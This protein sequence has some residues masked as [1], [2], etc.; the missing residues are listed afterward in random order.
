MVALWPPFGDALAAQE[1]PPSAQPEGSR[2]LATGIAGPS[3]TQTPKDSQGQTP[4]LAAPTMPAYSFPSADQRF[5]Q[6]LTRSFGPRAFLRPALQGALDQRRNEPEEWK[7]GASGYAKRYAS[8]FVQNAI[9]ETTRYGLSEAFRVEQKF[10]KCECTG[11]LPRLGHAVKESF[12]ART[13]R[14]REIPSVPSFVAPYAGSMV[15]VYTWYPGARQWKDSVRTGTLTLG[16]QPLGSI[17]REFFPAQ[18]RPRSKTA[19]AAGK[20]Q[21]T[22]DSQHGTMQIPLQ[23]KQEGSK[24]SGTAKHNGESRPVTGHID[25]NHVSFKF[26]AMPNINLDFT[27]TIEKNQMSGKAGQYE[28]PWKAVRPE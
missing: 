4:P 11:F 7:Q 19:N 16:L 25:G 24:L 21:L 10:H 14:G 22:L 9:S 6:Y 3:E 23:L 12:V 27:G 26:E 20:W 1:M 15:A 5:K 13:P 17:F 8:W 18:H 28:L 2:N